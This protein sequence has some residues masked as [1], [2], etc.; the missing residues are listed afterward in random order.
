MSATAYN[1]RMVQNWH[2]RTGLGAA[3][4]PIIIACAPPGAWMYIGEEEMDRV[5]AV[6]DIK[7]DD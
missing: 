2:A 1:V 5:R 6:Y 3:D 4:N 7:M